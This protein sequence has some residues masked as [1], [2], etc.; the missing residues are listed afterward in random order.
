MVDDRSSLELGD[1]CIFFATEFGQLESVSSSLK[2]LLALALF[3]KL[4]EGVGWGSGG[5]GRRSRSGSQSRPFLSA[6]TAMFQA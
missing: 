5:T 2:G 3:S 4:V 1:F 6:A